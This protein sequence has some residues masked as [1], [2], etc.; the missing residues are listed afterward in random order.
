MPI[1][2]FYCPVTL[3]TIGQLELP[4]DAAHHA[5]RVLRLRIGDAVQ[6][7]DGEGRACN[8]LINTMSGKQV[9][10]TITGSC[11]NQQKTPL[12]IVLV[13][14]MSSSEKM[15]WIIQK[16]TELGAA[17]AIFLPPIFLP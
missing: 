9:D 16:A 14:A 1:P 3:P 12:R 4:P 6:L 15:D 7:F 10:I 13:Q 2:R 8:G 5:H 11:P 17:E